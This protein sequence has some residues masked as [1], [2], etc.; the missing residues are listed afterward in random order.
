LPMR[1]RILDL[2]ISSV[3][4]QV[5][6]QPAARRGFEPTADFRDVT[7]EFLKTMGVPL[8]RGRGFTEHDDAESKR[9]MLINETL[10]KRYFAG[11]DPLGQRISLGSA[12]FEI[13][14]VVADVKLSGLE[15]SSEPAIYVPFKQN[16]PDAFSLVV[17]TAADAQSFSG[18]VRRAV[19]AVDSEQPVADVRT[20]SQVMK[21]NVAV[22][23]L[24]TWMLGVFAGLALLLASIGIYGLVSY[25]VTQRTREIGLRIALGAGTADILRSVARHAVVVCGIGGAAGLAAAFALAQFIRGLLYGVTATDPWAFTGAAVILALVAAAASYVPARRAMRIDPTVALRYE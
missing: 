25:S 24:S 11:R 9:V 17:S 6:G 21:D 14:G 2:R 23:R 15:R 3:S 8:R 1:G 16:A 7:P 12:P 20:M 22:R 13:V 5:E 19:L 4:F 18:A 10:A